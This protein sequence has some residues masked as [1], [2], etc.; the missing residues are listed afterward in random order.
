MDICHLTINPIDYERR[1]K[2]QAESSKNSG[3]TVWIVALGKPGEKT[4]VEIDEISV[5]RLKTP[6]YRGGVLKFI[7]FNLKLFF[8]LIFKPLDVLHCHDL[9]VTPAVYFLRLF[10]KFRFVYDAHEYFEGLEI[11]NK[12]KIRKR[13]WMVVEK[14]II[15]KVDV[16]VTVSE[17]IAYLYNKKYPKLKKTK[18]ILNVPKKEINWD[19]SGNRILPDIDKKI[20]LFQGHF[21][22]GRGLMQLIEAMSFTEKVHLVLIGG[23]ELEEEIKKKIQILNVEKIVSLMG[24]IPTDQLIK[25]ASGA[26]LGVVLFEQTSLN[27]TYALPNKFFE[28]IMAGIPILAS[29]LETFE[30]YIKMHKVGM[31]VNPHDVQKI[32]QSI[33]QMLSDEEQLNKWRKNAREASKILNWEN[34]SQKLNQIYE[35]NQT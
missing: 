25:T 29:N 16:L 26:D 28:Y 4:T 2:N 7:H 17:P 32:A 30:A 10:K 35:K 21:K 3:H 27:Y 1:I 15:G 14:T 6:F 22:P 24:Y 23:G 8:S 5:R 19:P 11:F 31:T 9:W 33:T 20:V 18:V 34:E 13:L 12:N